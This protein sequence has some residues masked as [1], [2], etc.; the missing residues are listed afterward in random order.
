MFFL[1]QTFVSVFW[2]KVFWLPE[3]ITFLWHNTCSIFLVYSCVC[4]NLLFLRQCILKCTTDV[5]R[6]NPLFEVVSFS[7]FESIGN[8]KRLHIQ[9]SSNNGPAESD[10]ILWLLHVRQVL[11]HMWPIHT[12]SP[13]IYYNAT[14]FHTPPAEFLMQT[15][16]VCGPHYCKHE[17]LSHCDFVSSTPIIMILCQ[18]KAV[19]MLLKG[20]QVAARK[21]NKRKNKRSWIAK[22]NKGWPDSEKL[23]A[24]FTTFMKLQF[25]V[26]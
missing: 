22:Q 12:K 8:I 1:F 11:E 26:N 14:A 13:H 5:V 2:L 3:G 25:H 6:G 18:L 15:I 16:T 4:L 21:K 19:N 24:Y 17:F 20:L 10:Y 9:C 7:Y 23:Q